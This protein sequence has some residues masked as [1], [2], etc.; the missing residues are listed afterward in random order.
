MSSAED[1]ITE[2]LVHLRF[3][4]RGPL[5]VLPWR[6]TWRLW[7]VLPREIHWIVLFSWFRYGLAVA[8]LRMLAMLESDLEFGCLWIGRLDISEDDSHGRT[9]QM[10]T[11]IECVCSSTKACV[12]LGTVQCTY[13]ADIHRTPT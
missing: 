1:S 2:T 3:V 5:G 6:A 12:H 10:T 4:V 8:I 7:N 13:V 9:A 11:L